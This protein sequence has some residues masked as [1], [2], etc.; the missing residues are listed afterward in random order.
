[1]SAIDWSV[2]I[3][4]HGEDADVPWFFKVSSD[5]AVWCSAFFAVTTA[6]AARAGLSPNDT[7]ELVIRSIE[8]MARVTPDASAREE[9]DCVVSVAADVLCEL[10]DGSTLP[11]VEGGAQ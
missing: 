6:L 4:A 10:L 9:V 2:W 7:G 11:G 8:T 5:E 3:D 1:M